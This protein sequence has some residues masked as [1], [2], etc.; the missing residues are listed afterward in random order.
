MANQTMFGPDVYVF[1]PSM[2]SSAIQQIADSIYNQQETNEFASQGYAL[3]FKPGS[4]HVDVKEGF[5]TQVAGLGQNPGDVTIDGNINA[6]AQ[7]NNGN[8]TDNFWRSVE[9][10]SVDP[11]DGVIDNGVKWDP[12]GM[13]WAVSQEAPIRRV[14]V[15]GNLDLF[16]FTSSWG[17]AMQAA[18]LW[19]TRWSM[20]KS[21]P[22]LSNS[23]CRATISMAA[24]ATVYGIWSS[25]VTRIHRAE[26]GLRS[27]IRSSGKRP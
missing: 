7:Y 27:H 25:L 24:G 9:N 11:T 17:L 8:A 4:Y 21:S 20:A 3:L 14:H 2:P 15:E 5:Y 1:D 16:D 19:P 22:P 13:Q 10:L 23:G 26:R 18:A 12:Q 6:N